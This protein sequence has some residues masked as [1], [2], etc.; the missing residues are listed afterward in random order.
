MRTV[1]PFDVSV[2]SEGSPA[3][4]ALETV[5]GFPIYPVGMSFP[6]FD[7]ALFGAEDPRLMFW[8]LYQM[9]SAG[10]AAGRIIVWG[11]RIGPN[12]A[13]IVPAAEGA[14]GL[15]GKAQ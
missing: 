7:A 12:A 3:I 8:D 15:F 5:H 2:S 9:T 11:F 14:Y 1:F 10:T 4:G 6:P 13:E